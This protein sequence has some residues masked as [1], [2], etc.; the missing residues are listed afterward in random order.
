MAPLSVATGYFTAPVDAA[1]TNRWA[2]YPCPPGTYCD[3]GAVIGCPPGTYGGTSGL[4]S[5][6]C[7]GL[8]A[9][10]FRCLGN[11]STPTPTRCSDG[12]QLP[13]NTSTQTLCTPPPAS[14]YCPPG[15]GLRPSVVHVGYYTVGPTNATDD[16]TMADETPCEPG[17]YCVD[18]SRYVCPAGQFGCS[19]HLTTAACSGSCVAGFYC[20]A[21]STLNT[22]L[23]CGGTAATSDAAAYYCPAG[24]GSRASVGDGNYTVGSPGDSPHVRTGQAV[25]PRGAYCSGGV[26]VRLPPADVSCSP[27]AT[28][29]EGALR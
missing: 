14:L 28:S 18:G 8:C 10:G 12:V 23:A 6:S 19:S 29:S 24:S 20:P 1:P 25:C 9:A 11:A 15:T 22:Q 16:A 26:Q 21:G 4:S 17:H 27:L 13:C 5:S 7:S 2:Q 3:G